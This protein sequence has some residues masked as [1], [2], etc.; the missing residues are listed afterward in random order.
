MARSKTSKPFR[1][2]CQFCNRVGH[3][4]NIEMELLCRW[5][6]RWAKYRLQP[7]KKIIVYYPS[8]RMVIEVYQVKKQSKPCTVCSTLTPTNKDCIDCKKVKEMERLEIEI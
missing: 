8:N 4:K 5:C 6:N 3:T 2:R 1:I 7:M